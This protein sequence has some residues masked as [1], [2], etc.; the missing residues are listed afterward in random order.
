[1]SD[2]EGFYV[3]FAGLV[4]VLLDHPLMFGYCYTQLTDVFQ[5]QN[6]IY[7]FDRTTK[8]DIARIKKI[9]TRQAAYENRSPDLLAITPLEDRCAPT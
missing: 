5:E 3:R 7:R 2:E 4:D 9:Q 1:V 6:G 8:L